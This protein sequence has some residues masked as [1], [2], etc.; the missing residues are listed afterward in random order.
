MPLL[1]SFIAGF[2][3]LSGQPSPLVDQG[4]HPQVGRS[5]Q[6]GATAWGYVGVYLGDL[7]ADRAREL[8]LPGVYGVIVGK[9][10]EGSPAAKSGI[11][12]NDCLLTLDGKQIIGRIQFFQTLMSSSPGRKVRIG[13]IRDGS[14]LELEVELGVRIS[15]EM[16]QRNRLFNEANALLRFAEENKRLAEESRAKGDEKA[17]ASYIDNEQTLRRL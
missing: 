11:R 15:R 14:R 1:M 9:V 4:E 7:T 2:L 5:L 3:L 8:G 12:E 17:A 13:M 10:E 16:E 6:Q